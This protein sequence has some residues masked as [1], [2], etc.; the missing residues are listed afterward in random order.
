MAPR[1]S[2]QNGLTWMLRFTTSTG[3]S[4][5][6]LGLLLPELGHPGEQ[7]RDPGGAV[8]DHGDLQ[9]GEARQGAVAHERGDGVLDRAPHGEGAERVGLEGQE[10]TGTPGP[11]VGVAVV[12][13]VGG[14]QGDEDVVLDDPLPEG[15]NSGS[16]IEREPLAAG[17][18][19]GPDEHHLGA[20]L[21]THSSSSIA[22]STM[23]RVMTGVEKIRPS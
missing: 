15:S 22:R 20:A 8:L 1:S 6:G 7:R 5:N 3:F 16:A 13:A 19:G 4:A 2:S 9:V 18:G 12:A 23:G 10:L 17:D 14:V 11:V 21:D